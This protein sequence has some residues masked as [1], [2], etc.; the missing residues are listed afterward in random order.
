MI[1]RVA[2]GLPLTASIQEDEQVRFFL[3][4]KQLLST[5]K[6]LF[7]EV[8]IKNFSFYCSNN[9][10]FFRN[11]MFLYLFFHFLNFTFVYINSKPSL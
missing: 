11:V 9:L 6:L 2:D 10:Y 7:L 5:N 1:A 4:L 3:N 8:L